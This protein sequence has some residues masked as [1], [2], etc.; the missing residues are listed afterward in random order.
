MCEFSEKLVAWLD[1]ELSVEEAAN[2]A[3][4]LWAC[5]ECRDQVVAYRHLSETIDA[6]CDA[7]LVSE[8]RRRLKARVWR[9]VLTAAAVAAAVLFIFFLGFRERLQ[10]P[11]FPKPDGAPAIAR[12]VPPVP[13]TALEKLSTAATAETTPSRL[14]NHRPQR[15]SAAPAPSPNRNENWLPNEAPVYIAI[16][17]DA[18]FPPGALPE[19]VGFVADVNLRPDGSPQRLR[20]QPQLVGLQRRGLDREK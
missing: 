15:K 18:L 11:F 20:L 2:V 10:S 4:H 5:A 3:Q 12:K 16:P 8:A 13:A 6:Y 7:A 1:Q 9:P 17:A 14:S 19:G